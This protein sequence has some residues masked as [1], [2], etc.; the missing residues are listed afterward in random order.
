M[1]R[2]IGTHPGSRVSRVH[3]VDQKVR[4]G[5]FSWSPPVYKQL[6]ISAMAKCKEFLDLEYPPGI[7][8]YMCAALARETGHNSWSTVKRYIR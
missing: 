6:T 4:S 2:F 1:D 3:I 5:R 8:R 7:L